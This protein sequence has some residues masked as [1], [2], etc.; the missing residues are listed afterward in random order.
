MA[1]GGDS[2]GGTGTVADR[3]SAI[4]RLRRLEEELVRAQEELA[5][6]GATEAPG[7]HLVLEAAGRRGLLP[8][9]RVQEVV[10]LVALEPLPSAPPAVLGTFVCRGAVTVAVSLAAVLGTPREPELD[11]QI[12]VLAGAPAVGLVVD[13]IHGLVDGPAVHSGGGQAP[14]WEGSRLV[15]GLCLVDGEVVPLL[16]PTP[17]EAL[18]RGGRA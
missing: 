5:S 18:A 9:T 3:A 8:A 11:A 12:A 17:I 1:S 2:Q 7:L 10:R 14:G 4:E 15:A 6:L 13:R 16:D